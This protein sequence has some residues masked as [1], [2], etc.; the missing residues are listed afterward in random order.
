MLL[1]TVTLVPLIFGAYSFIDIQLSAVQASQQKLAG[2]YD[3]DSLNDIEQQLIDSRINGSAGSLKAKLLSGLSFWNNSGQDYPRSQSQYFEFK[4]IVNKNSFDQQGLNDLTDSVSSLK[5]YMA[6]ESGLS[7]DSEPATFYLNDLYLTKLPIVNDFSSRVSAQAQQ[8]LKAGSFTPDSYTYLVAVSKRLAELNGTLN[9]STKRLQ[10]F[11][12]ENSEWVNAVKALQNSTQ[13]LLDSV[14]QKIIEPD[15]FTINSSEFSQNI[16]K[17]QRALSRL[18][19][20]TSDLVERIQKQKVMQ[21]ESNMLYLVLFVL[22]VVMLSL[23]FFLSAFKAISENVQII[24]KMTSNV[25]NGDLSQNLVIN[26]KDEFNEIANAF[27]QM[28]GSMRNLISEVQQLSQDVVMASEQVQQITEKVEQNLHAQQ[29]DTHQ[30]ASAISQ[31]VASV[32]AVGRNTEQ[33]TDITASAQQDVEQGQVVILQTVDG[34]NLIAKEV[35]LG[36]EVINQLAQ[37]ADDIG[38]VVDVIHGIAEQTNLLALNAAIEAARAGEQGRGFAVVAD[39]VRTLASRTAKSTDEIRRMIELVQSAT[40]KAV[41]TMESG[42]QRANEGVEHA[43]EVSTSIDNVTR[44]VQE[45]VVLSQQIAEVVAEQ[46]LATGQV[47]EK[48]HAIERGAADS[49][50]AAQSASGI[51]K[52]L[53][54]DAKKLAAQISDFKI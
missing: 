37:H 28:L 25:A 45:V 19:Q 36:A 40:S 35:S 22:A 7:L 48:T 23:Y 21:Q 46:R 11:Y 52:V 14:S 50:T 53:A 31:L 33:A 10:E 41:E 18:Q 6:A 16:S 12:G 3:I 26:S 24:N 42:S 38:K 51:G 27:N 49:L 17:Q 1:A 44:R 54:Q 20:N 47:D 5:E 13:S 29:E 32:E 2:K 43:N 8:I 4:Q 34:I 39:E 15:E 30:V 9:K